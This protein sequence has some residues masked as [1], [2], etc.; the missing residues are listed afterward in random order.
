MVSRRNWRYVSNINE[1]MHDRGCRTRWH[2]LVVSQIS[3]CLS[4][5]TAKW[6][7]YDA[8]NLQLQGAIQRKKKES[9]EI[10]STSTW[11]RRNRQRSWPC[12]GA[13]PV[14]RKVSMEQCQCGIE[15]RNLVLVGV[16][17]NGVADLLGC[18]LVVL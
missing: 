6:F 10:L 15:K 7:V 14:T 13:T 3:G 9:N 4:V 11:T 8:K 18:G 2:R 1:R 12:Q 5:I 16:I 17:A